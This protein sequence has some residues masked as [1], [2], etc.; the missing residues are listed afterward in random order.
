MQV[1]IR[2][3]NFY[4]SWVFGTF[5]NIAND[6]LNFFEE[7][8]NYTVLNIFYYSKLQ[9][10]KSDFVHEVVRLCEDIVDF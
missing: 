3:A 1:T 2:L 8:S 10:T 6:P 9:V 4:F 5:L 7:N